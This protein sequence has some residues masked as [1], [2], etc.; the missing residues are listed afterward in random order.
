MP[1]PPVKDLAMWPSRRVSF[2]ERYATLRS[3]RGRHVLV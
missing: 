3:Q 1:L 2:I